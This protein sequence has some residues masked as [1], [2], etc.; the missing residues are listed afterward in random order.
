[1]DLQSKKN[2]KNKINSMW[3]A[4][5]LKYLPINTESW[6]IR[7]ELLQVFMTEQIITNQEIESEN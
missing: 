2:Y 7:R 6:L 3:K 4:A 1:M 5:Q